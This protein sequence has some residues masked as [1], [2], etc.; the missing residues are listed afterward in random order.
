MRSSRTNNKGLTVPE[1]MAQRPFR[2]PRFH[3]VN[4]ITDR[5]ESFR[6]DIVFRAVEWIVRAGFRKR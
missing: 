4:E 3:C 5:R 1:L 2:Y 6:C